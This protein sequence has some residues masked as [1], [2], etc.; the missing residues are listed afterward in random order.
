V[1]QAALAAVLILPIAAVY[2]ARPEQRAL[3]VPAA[4]RGP[5][6]V[7]WADA[8][9]LAR[10]LDSHTR[11]DETVFVSD[12][13]PEILWLADR[14]APSRIFDEYSLTASRG[15]RGERL[16]ALRRHPPAAFVA[17]ARDRLDPEIAALVARLGYREVLDSP[18]GRIWM[19]GSSA[20]AG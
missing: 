2:V 9:P 4:A 3:K 11:S 1:P 6:G 18:A 7:P 20:A 19:R 13:Q 17:L 10:Y 5:N 15:Y 16:A 8:Y 14:R 12:S